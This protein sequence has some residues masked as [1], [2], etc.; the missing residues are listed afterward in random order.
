MAGVVQREEKRKQWAGWAA[1]KRRTL[2]DRNKSEALRCFARSKLRGK[3]RYGLTGERDAL[4]RRPI[5]LNTCT[6][7]NGN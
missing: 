4:Q 6:Y 7:L 1:V 5:N 3:L 2:Q